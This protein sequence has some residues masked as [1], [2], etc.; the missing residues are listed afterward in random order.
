MRGSTPPCWCTGELACER[1]I[2][3][4]DRGSYPTGVKVGDAELA[5][6][7]LSRH[8]WHGEWGY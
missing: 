8:D 7:P 5:A 3:Q 2:A 1:R 4:A 6:V